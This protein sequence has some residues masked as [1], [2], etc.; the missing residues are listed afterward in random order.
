[1]YEKQNTRSCKHGAICGIIVLIYLNIQRLDVTYELT[2][3][4]AADK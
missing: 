3:E 1:M 2:L 4:I